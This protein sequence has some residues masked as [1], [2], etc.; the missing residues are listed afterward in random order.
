MCKRNEAIDFLVIRNPK[1][2]FSIRFTLAALPAQ[3]HENMDFSPFS[4]AAS[5]ALRLVT[6]RDHAYTQKVHF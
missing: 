3:I 6:P 5:E 4:S 1:V 2:A